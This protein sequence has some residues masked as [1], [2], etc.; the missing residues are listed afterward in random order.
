MILLFTDFGYEGPY[1]GQVK[2]ALARHAPDSAVI[3][4]MHDAPVFDPRA[5]AY[6]LASLAGEIPEGA[7][8]VGVV[9]PGVG[10]ARRPLAVLADGRWFVGPDNGLFELVM[11]W[12]KSLAVHEIVWRPQDLSASFHG[13]D[14]FAPMAARLLGGDS[15]GLKRLES[16]AVRRWD[17]LDDWAAVIY[18]DRFG[19]AVTGVRAS[20][21]APGT[22]VE[23][24]GRRLPRF[25]TFSEAESGQIFCYE[26]AT[27]LMELAVNQGNASQLGGIE[28]GSPISTFLPGEN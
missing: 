16:D 8:F 10:G 26:N 15:S 17:W 25:K 23:I 27:G 28:L 7:A 14:L 6:L 1:V 13:R 9:D 5:S 21:L 20:S 12:S 24:N 18:I 11:R 2:L 4:L 19:N 3:D 22:S